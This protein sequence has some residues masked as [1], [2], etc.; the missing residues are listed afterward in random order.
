MGLRPRTARRLALVAAVFIVFVVGGV[1]LL[2]V[3]RWQ[4]SRSLAEFERSGMVA[5]EEGRHHEAVTLLSRHIRGMGERP[6]DPDVRLALARSRAHWEVS[7]GG[8]VRAAVAMYRA[9]LRERPDD[10]SASRELVALFTR[11]GMWLEA[12][13]LAARLRDEEVARAADDMLPVL[14][15]EAKARFQIDPDDP[16]I[17]EIEARL[18]G[19]ADPNFS[20]AWAA[21]ARRS[22][23]DVA[24]VRAVVERYAAAAP[25]SLGA[26]VL[27]ILEG[28]LDDEGQAR[29]ALA[30]VSGKLAEAMGLDPA[31][32]LWADKSVLTDAELAR[33]LV[34]AFDLGGRKDWSIRVLEL[35][36]DSLSEV[37]F[38]RTLARRLFWTGKTEELSG[39]EAADSNGVL[40]PDVLGYQALT[41]LNAGD[42]KKLGDLTAGIESVQHEFR[43]KAWLDLLVAKRALNAGEA[44]EARAMV[45]KAIDRYPYEPTFRL[46]AGDVQAQLGRSGEAIESWALA[47]D[48]AQPVVWTDPQFRRVAELLRLGRA[49]EAGDVVRELVV[50]APNNLGVLSLSVRVSA[51]LARS[52]LIS[53]A[54]IDRAIRLAQI[55]RP[56]LGEA[57]SSDIGLSIALLHAASGDLKAARTELAGVLSSP[58][59]S[60]LQVRAMEID[61]RFGLGLAAELGRTAL[62]ERIDNPGL[63]V[64]SA[65]TYVLGDAEGR[66]GRVEEAADMLER[67]LEASEPGDRLAWLRA[68]ASFQ[69]HVSPETAAGAWKAAI[70]A[71]PTNIDLLTEAASSEALGYDRDFVDRTIGK[72]VDLTASQGR[73]LPSH[74]RI[75]KA[76]SVFGR[77]PTRAN[78]EEAVAILRSV[79]ASEPRNITARTTLA[80][81]LRHECSPELEDDDR[82]EPD[83]S[84][85][86]E[87]Y[88][89][90]AAQIEGPEALGYLFEAADLHT[91][92]GEPDAA[93]EVLLDVFTRVQNDPA[94]QQRVAE[95]M[96]DLGAGRDAAR[97]LDTVFADAQGPGRIG[98]GLL[99]VKTYITLNDPTRALEVL[100]DLRDEPSMTV[101]QVLELAR[102]F[103]QAG[104]GDDAAAV[105]SAGS[106]YGLSETDAQVVAAR[107]A[108][109]FGD[110]A[111]AEEILGALVKAEPGRADHWVELTRILFEQGKKGEAAANAEA[112]LAVHPDSVD[113]RY[114]RE[115]ALGNTAAA[116]EHA[117]SD[118]DPRVRLAVKGVEDYERRKATLDRAQR[119]AELGVLAGSFPE[120]SAVLKYTLRERQGLRDRPE[121]L[122][123]D[124]ATASRRFPDDTD[125]LRIA[126]QTSLA[127]N[128]AD[129][130]AFAAAWRGRA[131]GSP[132]E[133]DIY[134][135]QAR[136]LLGD[137]SGAAELLAPYLPS[138]M[139]DP[140]NPYYQQVLLTHARSDIRLNGA[141]P[142]RD[143]I[144]PLAAASLAVR[145]TIWLD[146]AAT[147]VPD[148]ATAASWLRAADGWEMA[149]FQ[150]R[151]A[152]A[153]ARAADR[154]PQQGGP[155]WQGALDAAEKALL[156]TPGSTEAAGARATALSHI[157]ESK[158]GP[159]APG[160]FARA[161]E[162]ALKAARLEPANLNWLF[163]AAGSASEAGDDAAAEKH[164][165]ALLNEP[166][167]TGLFAA[168]VRNNLAILL[169]R[170]SPTQ[171]RLSEA[172]GLVNA[173]IA[174]EGDIG[175]FYETRGWVHHAMGHFSEALADFDRVVQIEPASLAGWVGLAV[176]R[177]SGPNPDQAGSD[178]ALDQVS[179]LSAGS[180]LEPSVARRLSAAGLSL[181]SD[182]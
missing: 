4:R 95:E 115:L 97:I 114:W 93:R 34:R 108:V 79:V 102:L 66:D 99:L 27:V 167:C 80:N 122:A 60:A 86:I 63:A 144:E 61:R 5:H 155:L 75:A 85:A 18:L 30:D 156:T 142:V 165:R 177:R 125:L 159:E 176:A 137:H 81:M 90:A 77:A 129:A 171:A 48:L 15:D 55:I 59:G 2:T 126:T 179:R 14:R 41:A 29:P 132:L 175:A 83:I 50:L 7:D 141:R 12:R 146:L 173:A 153:W 105:V 149:E 133:P 76:R 169:S 178:A 9:Y 46:I 107:F 112:G 35:A 152:N 160:W 94:A 21:I 20:D 139:A 124:A 145:S 151:V 116:L 96:R 31:T 69:D 51:A 8:H 1:A 23:G 134:A 87:Q 121:G 106:G 82:F 52:G 123:A 39:M 88:L 84:G 100:D 119:L 138:A 140:E 103:A 16:V 71:D 136:Q 26:R 53:E 168:A 127:T 47:T 17:A 180:E 62:P 158:P 37:E 182:N 33:V 157:A 181:M 11:A 38:P 49:S 104:R 135:A 67:G 57:Q 74:L 161:A 143:R 128:P 3:P 163:L 6:V 36:T 109:S 117:V 25:D 28:G 43:A 56:V 147:S 154:F 101:D 170:T 162:A 64:R 44:V 10:E 13:D 68:I 150:P 166:T 120:N 89:A 65:L 78:R 164:Y 32:G 111:R 172:L 24:G 72:V 148:A 40:I 45:S 130:L 58:A 22:A 19:A 113:L 118:A 98:T 70:E 54:E 42:E 91:R 131:G 92:I 110:L 73:T 174:E